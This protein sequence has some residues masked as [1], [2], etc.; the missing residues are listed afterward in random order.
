MRLTSLQGEEK[1]MAR[2]SR[3]S[4]ALTAIIV[5]GFGWNLVFDRD[6]TPTPDELVLFS[7]EWDFVSK[8]PPQDAELL[9][10]YLVLGKIK[11][12]EPDSV[13]EIFSAVR[14][15]LAAPGPPAAC[16]WPR[17]AVRV[18]EKGKTVDYVICFQ[19]FQCNGYE[20]TVGDKLV[21]TSRPIG[22]TSQPILNRYL[23][24]AGVPLSPGAECK[25]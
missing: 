10:G 13:K 14:K 21:T 23:R 19:C 6:H 22:R 20:V 12:Q 9:H 17:H 3:Y 24:A 16:F 8:K 5:I 11:I 25:L 4:L 7:L 2:R 1:F 15:D 18:V